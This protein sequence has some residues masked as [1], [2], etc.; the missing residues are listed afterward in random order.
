[1]DCKFCGTENPDSA[2]FCKHC[3]KPMN[4]MFVCPVCGKQSPADGAFCI[5]C[6]SRLAPQSA[7]LA[8]ET[9]IAQAAPAQTF[10]PQPEQTADK[11]KDKTSPALW[12]KA[13]TYAG[14]ACALFAALC[15]MIFVFC[16]GCAA[17][18]SALSETFG[19]QGIDLYYYF[20]DVYRDLQDALDATFRPSDF[21][22]AT[23]YIQA[24]CGT[25]VSAAAIITVPVLFVVTLVRYIRNLTG[26][27]E[28]TANS[29]AAVTYFIFIAFA[30]MFLGLHAV[31]V[32]YSTDNI[33]GIGIDATVAVKLNSATV[34]GLILGGVGIGI[35]AVCSAAVRGKD[36]LQT[37][38]IL[39]YAFSAAAVVLV[40]VALSLLSGAVA[41]FGAEG[42]GS[43]ARVSFG[44]MQALAL[45]GQWDFS[46]NNS[47]PSRFD[48]ECTMI[49]IDSCIGIVVLIAFA[50]LATMLLTTLAR[51]ISDGK[52]DKA[53]LVVYAALL[54]VFAIILTVCAALLAQDVAFLAA[55]IYDLE[56]DPL[57]PFFTLPIIATVLSVLALTALIVYAALSTKKTPENA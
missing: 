57:S 6:G 48:E 21:Y 34:T 26:A 10:E 15:A 31:Q 29:V 54:A 53:R 20:G 23:L 37:P 3:G 16:I 7:A 9:A 41:G 14:G 36:N 12:Q 5:Y 19:I 17:E 25:L 18:G 33:A 49:V 47:L 4:G 42:S 50:V 28:K 40:L 24:I 52:P 22:T 55:E 51:G 1:M 43:S 2:V 30:L 35:S 8:E 39:Q 13:L 38:R 27:S 45:C 56:G 46:E 32:T 44:F 11:G